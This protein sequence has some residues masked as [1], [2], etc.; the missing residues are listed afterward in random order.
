MGILNG[1]STVL[2]EFFSMTRVVLGKAQEGIYC[3]LVVLVALNLNNHL[4]Q[5]KDDL[6]AALPRHL[7]IHKVSRAFPVLPRA[8]F[9]LVR[10]ILRHTVS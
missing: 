9:V 1:A 8:L 6:L 2:G 4:F 5:P 7:V 3:L 10:D